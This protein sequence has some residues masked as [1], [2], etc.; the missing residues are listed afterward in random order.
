MTPYGGHSLLPSGQALIYSLGFDTMLTSS[1]VLG[2]SWYS[3]HM[4]LISVRK[5]Q[6]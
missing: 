4:R 2:S 6:P 5:I 3:L 1:L